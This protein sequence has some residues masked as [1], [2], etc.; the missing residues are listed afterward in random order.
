MPQ[1]FVLLL[2]LSSA[3]AYDS[4]CFAGTEGEGM[5]GCR[6]GKEREVVLSAVKYST[7]M[8]QNIEDESRDLFKPRFVLF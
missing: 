2:V 7:N 1:L 8:V 3:Q 6:E 5:G 4:G